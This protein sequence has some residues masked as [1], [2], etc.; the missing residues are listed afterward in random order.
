MEQMKISKNAVFMRRIQYLALAPDIQEFIRRY[1]E[2]PDE[3]KLQTNQIIQ[4]LKRAE[5][6]TTE[7]LISISKND[8]NFWLIPSLIGAEANINAPSNYCNFTP[9]H[10]A[11]FYGCS[12]TSNALMEHHA[13]IGI[14]DKQGNT[15]LHIAAKFGHLG[16]VKVLIKFSADINAP[17]DARPA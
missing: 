2:I 7:A 15:P 14:P 1:L 16:V 3:Q 6:S 9:L 17:S 11:A 5:F 8:V 12:Q 13:L 4:A 10:W